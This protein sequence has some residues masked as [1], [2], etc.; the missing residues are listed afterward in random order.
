VET[1][2]DLWAAAVEGPRDFP[3][4][5]VPDDGAWQAVS[6]AEAAGLVDELAAG[7]VALGIE[8]RDRVAV[9]AGTRLEWTLVDLALTSVGAVTV[10]IYPTSSALECA[11]VVGNAGVRMAV[12]EDAGQH[13]KIAPLRR[14]SEILDRIVV[15]DE[16]PPGTLGLDGVRQAG[17]EAG[18]PAAATVRERR[19][20]TRPDDVLTIIY[21]SGTT[22]PPKGCVITHGNLASMVASVGRIPDFLRSGDRV[23]LYLPLAHNFARLVQFASVGIGMTVAFCPEI[24]R[25]PQAL[26]EVRPTILPSVP[27]LFEKVMVG[28][29][30][31]LGQAAGARGRLARW[32]LEVGTEASDLE[33]DGRPLP[34]S[35]ALR[36]SLADRLVFAKVRAR[37]GGRLRFAVSGGAPLRTD[38]AEYFHAL[39][40]VILEGYGLTE[41][42]AA[43]HVNR[44]GYER[45]GSVGQPVPDI[46]ARCAPDGELLL[47]GPMVF[48][49][50][51]GDEKATR[52]VVDGEGWLHTGDIG[53]ID[54]SGYLTITDRKKDLIVTSGGK[55]VSPQPIE[56]ALRASRY[57]SQALVVG[58]GRPYLTAL[59]ALERAEVERAAH[60]DGDARALVERVVV[61]VNRDLSRPEQIKRFTIVPREF[62][63]EEGEVT[64][65]LKLRRHVCE[66]HFASEIETMYAGS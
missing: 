25:I 63:P 31:S 36:R 9:L 20:A 15:M 13:A 57:V 59:V 48:A 27:R 61:E 29:S 4:F 37:L 40:I 7:F 62:L 21:T 65:T 49:G 18:E 3:A 12:C 55:N 41:C 39:G 32:A 16:A 28:I 51:H 1:I 44:P 8:R 54:E 33:R 53:A 35:L 17:R 5:L 52:E 38:V 42:T 11:Y 56:N 6:W 19:S 10:P 46:E 34:P 22:G 50:Y 30:D 60:A 58:E 23:L 47:R 14:Q 45:F 26:V 24:D 64:P 2:T 43:S 66:E